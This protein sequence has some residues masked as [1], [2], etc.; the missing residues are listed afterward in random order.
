[1][2]NNIVQSIREEL[3]RLADEKTRLNYDRFF[4]EKVVYY[5]VKTSVVASIAKRYYKQIEPLGKAGIF[6]LC[7][8]LL[9]SN[10]SEEA[11]IACEWSYRLRSEYEIND[12]GVFERW[13]NDYINDWAK[14][15]TFCNHTL[16]S[17]IDKYPDFIGKLKEWTQSENRWLKRAAS[18]TLIIPARKGMFLSDIFEIAD[19]L[20]TDKD[21]LVQKGYGWMLK[22]A[23]IKHCH[24]IFNY[25]MAHKWQMPRTALRYA[26]ERMPADLKKQA[27]EK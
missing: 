7:E 9:K 27:M 26:I 5:G 10:Y 6:S 22:D 3:V 17:F 19:K 18:V 4:K 12:F 14:C 2:K 24:E 20:L 11:F 15:D 8:E 25:I 21:D 16:G 1:M 23:S 13:L